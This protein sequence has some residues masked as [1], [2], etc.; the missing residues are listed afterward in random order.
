MN[1]Y[2]YEIILLAD[3]LDEAERKMRV[4]GFGVP[5][6][7][8]CKTSIMD[9]IGGSPSDKTSEGWITLTEKEEKLVKFLRKEEEFNKIMDYL[10]EDFSRIDLLA[11]IVSPKKTKQK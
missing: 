5:G 1:R 10:Y 9:M 8:Q 7:V 6:F 2:K 4:I 3:S 11:E